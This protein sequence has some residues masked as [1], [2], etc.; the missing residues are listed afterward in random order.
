MAIQ[1]GAVRREQLVQ[2]PGFRVD[3]VLKNSG[4][5]PGYELTTWIYTSVSDSNGSLPFSEP[6]PISERTGKSVIGPGSEAL[7]TQFNVL[8]NDD[9]L[10]VH[11]GSKS[12]FVWGGADYK[13]VFGT[14][15]R[16]IFRCVVAGPE[17]QP[18]V[19]PLTPHTLGYEAD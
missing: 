15:R 18:G 4:Q 10:N 11:A 16:F 3:V 1:G 9:L 19:W 6:R 8:T 5:P 17:N 2:G 7:I 12:I 13:D 14:P